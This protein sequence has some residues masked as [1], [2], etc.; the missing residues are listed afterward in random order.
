MLFSDDGPFRSAASALFS[1]IQL[2]PY[3]SAD[4]LYEVNLKYYFYN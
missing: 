3:Y 1:E 4:P 2:I